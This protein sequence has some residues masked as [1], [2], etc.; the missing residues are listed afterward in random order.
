MA[1][2]QM[3]CIQGILQ[4]QIDRAL[5]FSSLRLNSDMAPP[6]DAQRAVFEINTNMDDVRA[7]IPPML[8][9]VH[10]TL[11]TG[12]VRK[13]ADGVIE[14]LP[15]SL[16]PTRPNDEAR[17]TRRAGDALDGKWTV[18]WLNGSTVLHGASFCSHAIWN[19]ALRTARRSSP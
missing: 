12:L 2:V 16:W 14:E 1:S 3:P 4:I 18:E 19:C 10:D 5:M 9:H 15:Q 13:A 17:E 6:H 8:L 11:Y 7:V